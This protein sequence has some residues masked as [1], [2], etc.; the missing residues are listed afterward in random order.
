MK[1][2]FLF[3]MIVLG[4]FAFFSV[5]KAQQQ[6]KSK[7][8]WE[9]V[10]LSKD[11]ATYAQFLEENPQTEH[12]DEIKVLVN[13]FLN[14]K[15][16]KAKQEGYEVIENA[17]LIP[18]IYSGGTKF[19]LGGGK[20]VLGPVEFYSDPTKMLVVE[21]TGEG[22]K[23]V[24]GKGLGITDKKIYIFQNTKGLELV[25]K[26]L[27]IEISLD[28]GQKKKTK[29]IEY[30]VLLAA[31]AEFPPSLKNIE[32]E[33][34]SITTSGSMQARN[35]NGTVIESEKILKDLAASA[36]FEPPKVDFKNQVLFALSCKSAFCIGI[37]VDHIWIRDGEL[38]GIVCTYE[39]NKDKSSGKKPLTIVAVPRAIVGNV[40]ASKSAA[41]PLQEKQ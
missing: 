31:S 18:G 16:A 7:L 8:K 4:F 12:L 6:E 22:I 34:N 32:A 25:R 14:D 11:I 21:L 15:V 30:Q 41:R 9:E 36:N 24:T 5:V 37:S 13:D 10:S 26:E 35:H 33:I 20:I 3:F 29:V 39:L 17:S 40:K 23:Y 27:E 28:E 19:T 2:T 38:D 1:K